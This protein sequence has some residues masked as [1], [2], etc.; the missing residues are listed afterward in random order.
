VGQLTTS[1]VNVAPPLVGNGASLT[2][3]LEAVTCRVKAPGPSR[4]IEPTGLGTTTIGTYTG[5]GM[6]GSAAL[7]VL[8]AGASEGMLAE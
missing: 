1:I 2:E 4:V 7:I 5:V 3:G 6:T 8:R